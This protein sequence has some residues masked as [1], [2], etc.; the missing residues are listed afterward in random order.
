MKD[1]V[2]HDLLS[3]TLEEEKA[4]R[5]AGKLINL[6][7]DA[8]LDTLAGTIPDVEGGTFG[9]TLKNMQGKVLFHTGE[10]V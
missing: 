3:N 5:L 8:F 4:Y 7:A 10:K 1:G 6:Q 2:L 9:V